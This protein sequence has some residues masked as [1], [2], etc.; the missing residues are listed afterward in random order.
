VCVF[1]WCIS[2]SGTGDLVVGAPLADS[3]RSPMAGAVYLEGGILPAFLESVARSMTGR[4]IGS[5]ESSF[6]LLRMKISLTTTLGIP[7]KGYI[8]KS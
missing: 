8:Y 5:G 2:V 1:F 6:Q 7:S 3:S 4:H